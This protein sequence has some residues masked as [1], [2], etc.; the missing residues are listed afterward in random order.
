MCRNRLPFLSICLFSIQH[1]THFSPTLLQ[2]E[3]CQGRRNH[4]RT[5]YWGISFGEDRCYWTALMGPL[6]VQQVDKYLRFPFFTKK[7]QVYAEEVQKDKIMRSQ[8]DA[9]LRPHT[10]PHWDLGPVWTKKNF[11]SESK[12]ISRLGEPRPKNDRLSCRKDF[13]PTHMFRNKTSKPA[14]EEWS[15][16]GLKLQK[17]QIFILIKEKY[18]KD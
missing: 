13:F 7:P 18:G 10:W 4:A 8:S 3:H 11:F 2:L 15:D 1:N 9:K 14:S 17:M 16:P 5:N 12:A 6:E